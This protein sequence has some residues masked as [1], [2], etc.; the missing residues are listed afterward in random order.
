MKEKKT[1]TEPVL[2]KLFNEECLIFLKDERIE[3]CIRD[4]L[5]EDQKCFER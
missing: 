4:S 5:E 2:K 3:N 1:N